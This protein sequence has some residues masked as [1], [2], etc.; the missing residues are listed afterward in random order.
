MDYVNHLTIIIPAWGFRLLKKYSIIG[1]YLKETLGI[2][3]NS[4]DMRIGMSEGIYPY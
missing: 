4:H 3:T 1:N 2:H